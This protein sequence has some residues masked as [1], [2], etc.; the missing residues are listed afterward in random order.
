MVN[1][2]RGEQNGTPI[3]DFGLPALS[4][5]EGRI[6]DRIPQITQVSPIHLFGRF[7]AE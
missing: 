1:N 2:G 6:E 5:V 4:E 7:R 3:S